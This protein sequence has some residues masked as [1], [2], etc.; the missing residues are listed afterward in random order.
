LIIRVLLII[1]S[2]LLLSTYERRTGRKF[3]GRKEA[4]NLGETYPS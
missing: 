3:L 2:C 4:K 1:Y